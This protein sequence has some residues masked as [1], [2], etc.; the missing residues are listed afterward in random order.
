MFIQLLE[1]SGCRQH[2]VWERTWKD[3]HI[4]DTRTN[5][6]R[7]VTGLRVPH[8]AK[9]GYRICVFR[10][11]SLIELKMLLK[12]MCPEVTDDDYLFRNHQTNTIIDKSTFSKY[13]N[14]IMDRNTLSYSLRTFRSHRIA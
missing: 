9:R 1:D 2:E 10:G 4:G 14:L 12:M 13:W 5:R 11:D 6:K 8:A 7:I 3:V